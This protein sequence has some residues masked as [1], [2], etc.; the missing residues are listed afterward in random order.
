VRRNEIHK[1]VKEAW[2]KAQDSSDNSNGS[3]EREKPWE[4]AA[5]PIVRFLPIPSLYEDV[6]DFSDVSGNAYYCL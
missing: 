3:Q 1:K 4:P 2:T 6:G 5:K